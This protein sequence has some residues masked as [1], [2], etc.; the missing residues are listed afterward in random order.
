MSAKLLRNLATSFVAL[1]STFFA[2][3]WWR[4]SGG[5]VIN[6]YP[7]IS[8]D[9]FDWYL[10]GV[11][12]IKLFKSTQVLDSLPILRPPVFVLIAAADYIAGARG[13]VLALVSGLSIFCTYIF[14][15]LLIDGHLIRPNI[16]SWQAFFVAI[17]ITIYPLDF[18]R[19][20]LL[21]DG[22]AIM[23]ALGSI[24]MWSRYQIGL[25]RKYIIFSI[26]FASFAGLTQTYALLPFLIM[27]AVG[28]ISNFNGNKLFSRLYFF[29]AL[30]VIAL[31]L[32]GTF[33][34]RRLMPHNGT[35]EN[36]TLLQ[37]SGN[38]LTFYLQTWSF[39]FLPLGI[40]FLLPR[41]YKLII[42]SKDFFIKAILLIVVVFGLLS[43]FYQWPEAR[44][45]YYLWPWV[46]ILFGTQVR[47]L[48]RRPI[49]LIIPLMA[50][51]IVLVP[52]NYWAPSWGSIKFSPSQSWVI[53]YF[54]ATPV[55]RGLNFCY[56]QCETDNEFLKYSDDYVK[57]TV[58]L[59]L[60]V[61]GL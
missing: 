18:I 46:M 13:L 33:Y 47:P 56:E 50:I 45:T 14:S 51:L 17:G 5:D 59:Y 37:F 22:L 42:D 4:L 57:S 21:A 55:D 39:Y 3:N 19:P 30:I 11:Y 48:S 20:Y 41:S 61:K 58:K 9:G 53:R 49:F 24:V 23:L 44:F 60:K 32:A 28:L 31:Y 12:L 26:F 54:S 36:F 40:F 10:E 8:P 25:K 7:F 34:W 27:C 1:F 6:H 2:Y 29:S 35:P 43:F 38:M 52:Q 16:V 15:L